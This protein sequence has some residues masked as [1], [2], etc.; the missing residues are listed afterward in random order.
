M[1]CPKCGVHDAN[2]GA[3]VMLRLSGGE[4]PVGFCTECDYTAAT[5]EDYERDALALADTPI[6]SVELVKEMNTTA[7]EF[8]GGPLDM[9]TM[10]DVPV[11]M[12]VVVVDG[13]CD[14]GSMPRLARYTRD[15]D[16]PEIFT[17]DEKGRDPK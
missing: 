7:V 8:E 3:G 6:L 10:F 15:P 4:G 1:I 11:N 17:V 5:R 12:Q 14:D 16:Y 9:R 13:V 2:S